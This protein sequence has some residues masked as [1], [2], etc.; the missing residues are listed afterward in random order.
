MRDPI[1]LPAKGE[2]PLPRLFS[3]SR[4][5][6]EEAKWA[7]IFLLPN[8]VLFS[9]FTIYPV[10]ASFFYSLNKWTL[11]TPMEFLGLE[12]IAR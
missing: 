8:L 1:V 5:R 11:H 4:L 12:T 3:F 2:Y 6:W 9:I 10:F 7:Y